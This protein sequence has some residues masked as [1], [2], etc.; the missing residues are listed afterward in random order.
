M[1]PLTFWASPF[2]SV[3]LTVNNAMT[4][5]FQLSLGY[6]RKYRQLCRTPAFEPYAW[7]LAE[8]YGPKQCALLILIY[9]KHHR[10]SDSEQAALSC[11]DDYLDFMA[12]KHGQATTGGQ[13]QVPMAL[14][15]LVGLRGQLGTQS[16][17][18]TNIPTETRPRNSFSEMKDK[19]LW[20]L[21]MN[22][23]P[24]LHNTDLNL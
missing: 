3:E 19:D 18:Y 14:K 23:E 22:D 10:G 12:A 8:Y 13:L 5:I 9:L 21:L 16:F 15:V 4:R 20:D 6:L 24:G 17:D 1:F 2:K 7:L 11:V